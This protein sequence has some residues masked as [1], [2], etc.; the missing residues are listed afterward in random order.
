MAEK[1]HAPQVLFCI[2]RSVF[3]VFRAVEGIQP[4]CQQDTTGCV[5]KVGRNILNAHIRRQPLRNRAS[6]CVV[7][8]APLRL[9]M[10]QEVTNV[11]WPLLWFAKTLVDF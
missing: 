8:R 10:R 11:I 9:N 6:I 3:V 1:P 4:F 2:H 7:L 5:K